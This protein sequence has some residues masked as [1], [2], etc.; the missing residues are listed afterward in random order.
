MSRDMKLIMESWR[1]EVLQEQEVQTVGELKKVINSHRLAQTGKEAGK[2]AVSSFIEEVP[3]LGS[4]FRMFGVAKDSRE[5]LRKLYSAEDNFKTNTGLDKLNVDDNV[6]KIV[7]DEIEN[8]FL[9][10]L[11]DMLNGMSDSDEIPDVNVALQNFLK[12]K[13]N[14]HSVE[15]RQ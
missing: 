6:S 11:I 5:I 4:A 12:R 7:D 1:R 3:V 9:K 8:A 14:Q 13:F 10:A 2:L 15:A